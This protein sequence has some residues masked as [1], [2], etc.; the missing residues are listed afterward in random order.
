M[1]DRMRRRSVWQ[2]NC[3]TATQVETM[4]TGMGNGQ[5]LKFVALAYRQARGV[6]TMA[7]NV[8]RSRMTTLQLPT[9]LTD[10][11]L[12]N[13]GVTWAGTTTG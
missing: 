7:H 13:R 1:S 10:L 6:L 2:V 5:F 9:D 8:L 4:R 3:F 11:P 12:G